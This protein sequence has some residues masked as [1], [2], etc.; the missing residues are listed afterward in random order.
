MSLR[1]PVGSL[2]CKDPQSETEPTHIQ[3]RGHHGD[4]GNTAGRAGH[5]Q[6][7]HS[8]AEGRGQ[9]EGRPGEES[10]CYVKSAGK[11]HGGPLHM[12]TAR[13]IRIRNEPRQSHQDSSTQH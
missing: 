13:W 8:S 7:E 1:R 10:G 4:A 3:G 6:E 12:N 2:R 9:G 5:I 11:P